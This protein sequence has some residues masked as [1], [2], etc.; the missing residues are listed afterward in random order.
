MNFNTKSV[1]HFAC[2]KFN[3]QIVILS[4]DLL[5]LFLSIILLRLVHSLPIIFSIKFREK[6][7]LTFRGKIFSRLTLYPY[8][9]QWIAGSLHTTQT[10]RS[11]NFHHK[12]LTNAISAKIDECQ[13]SS[14]GSVGVLELREPKSKVLYPSELVLQSYDQRYLTYSR[15]LHEMKTRTIKQSLIL[16]QVRIEN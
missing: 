14:P 1:K 5:R 10:S 16:T 15:T 4:I 9:L 7:Q 11:Q 13:T 8:P 12:F 2:L 3:T 6:K